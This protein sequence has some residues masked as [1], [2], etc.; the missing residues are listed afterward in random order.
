MLTCSYYHIACI[1]IYISLSYSSSL[2]YVSEV[3][4][5]HIIYALLLILISCIR[6]ISWKLWYT[7]MS[8]LLY[9]T[10][11]WLAISWSSYW[12]H[13]IIPTMSY[14]SYYWFDIY[15]LL[16]IILL[17]SCLPTTCYIPK[18]DFQATMIWGPTWYLIYH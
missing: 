1:H 2:A 14:L 11:N 13:N 9:A 15:F 18:L 5:H 8:G 7:C 12:L 10:C 3:H 17:D 6:P 16:R 4:K